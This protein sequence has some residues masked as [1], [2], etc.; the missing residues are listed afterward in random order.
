[1]PCRLLLSSCRFCFQEGE[2]KEEEEEEEE[3]EGEIHV[4]RIYINMMSERPVPVK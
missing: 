1:M 3:E 2:E 4:T